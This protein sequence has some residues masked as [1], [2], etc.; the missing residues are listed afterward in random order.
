VTAL[1][2]GRRKFERERHGDTA[3]RREALAYL[4]VS[5]SGGPSGATIERK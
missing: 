2:E 5:S 1:K 3:A 4:I